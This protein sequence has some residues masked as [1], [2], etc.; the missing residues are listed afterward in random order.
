MNLQFERRVRP[1]ADVLVRR[2]E[3]ELVLMS[4][5]H[6]QYFGLDEVGTAMWEAPAAHPTIHDAYLA[7]IEE[8]DAD[9]DELRADLAALVESLAGRGLVE[10]TGS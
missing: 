5:E 10:L 3:T 4:L 6:E 8:Y 7:L 9:P 1:A 2:V